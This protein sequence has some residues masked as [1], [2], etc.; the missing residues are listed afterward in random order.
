M[1]AFVG[2]SPAADLR[3]M[4]SS[5][6]LARADLASLPDPVLRHCFLVALFLGDQAISLNPL[7][8]LDFECNRFFPRSWTT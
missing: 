1:S 6:R 8:T 7:L 4:E 5:E 2:V 3:V